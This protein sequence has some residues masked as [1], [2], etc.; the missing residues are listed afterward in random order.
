MRLVQPVPAV[1]LALTLGA[2]ASPVPKPPRPGPFPARVALLPLNNHS[3][4]LAGPVLIRHL[5]QGRLLGGRYNPPP[6]IEVDRKLKEIGITDGGQL[7]AVPPAKL[8]EVLGVDGLLMGDVLAFDR[9]T[10]GVM[11]KRKVEVSLRLVDAAGR[12]LWTATRKETTSKIGLTKD[13]IAENLAGGLT[14]KLIE[15]AL[16]NPL[17][18]ESEQVVHSLMKDLNRTRSAW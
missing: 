17:R 12:T 18:P 16:R 15:N 14:E 1:A 8:A 9:Q 13:A 10:L 2:C 7:G 4:N 6:E 3:N 11:N 5:I